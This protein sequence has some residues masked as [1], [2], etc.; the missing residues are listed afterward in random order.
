MAQHSQRKILCE[1]HHCCP[2]QGHGKHRPPC[3]S[4]GAC[5]QQFFGGQKSKGKTKQQIWHKLAED[6]CHRILRNEPSPRGSCP[7]T[8]GIPMVSIVAVATTRFIWRAAG[9]QHGRV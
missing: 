8:G 1:S 3:A 5:C 6:H 4:Q 7:I 9:S 2:S